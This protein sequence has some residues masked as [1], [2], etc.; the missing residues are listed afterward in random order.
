MRTQVIVVGAF[1]E[2]SRERIRSAVLAGGGEAVLC[3]C[4]E[5]GQAALVQVVPAGLLLDWRTPGGRE[6]LGWMRGE[7]RLFAVPVVVLLPSLDERSFVEAYASAA[8]DALV[9]VDDGSIARRVGLMTRFGSDGRVIPNQGRALVAHVEI[10][11]RRIIGR[12]FRRAGFDLSFASDR[13][14]LRAASHDLQRSSVLVVDEDLPP[15]GGLDAI[16]RLRSDTGE[17]VP[18]IVIV[19]SRDVH[20]IGPLTDLES[21]AVTSAGA[22]ADNLLFLT[23]ELLRPDIRDIRSSPRLLYST[24]CAFRRAG[25]LVSA[26]GLTYN[27]SRDG[28]YVRTMD[29]GPSELDIWVELRPPHAERAIHLRGRVIWVQGLSSTGLAPLGLGIRI[30]GEDCPAADLDAYR[31]G[32]QRLREIGRE[33]L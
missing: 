22:P 14:E 18:A 19:R 28:L 3:G 16:R 4:A 24:L 1:G 11:R 17:R 12:L 8:D 9:P 6:F 33:F 30:V 20:R 10:R 23:N 25:D 2:E 15:D 27:I 31:D 29:A 7:P 5:Q 21:V 32:Y 13:D 26:Y